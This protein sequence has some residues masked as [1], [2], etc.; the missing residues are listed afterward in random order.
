VK[1][2]T[3]KADNVE[4]IRNDNSIHIH[5]FSGYPEHDSSFMKEGHGVETEGSDA[6][7]Y[8]PCSKDS[9]LLSARD[10]YNGLHGNGKAWIGHP[11]KNVDWTPKPPNE[12]KGWEWFWFCCQCDRG[13]NVVGVLNGI[14]ALIIGGTYLWLNK[15]MGLNHPSQI[16][17]WVAIHDTEIEKVLTTHNRSP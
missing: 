4:V 12:I 1:Y 15:S 16:M 14:S 13:S 7:K 3:P 5:I 6:L 10:L 2:T 11:A 9:T 8:F 17:N